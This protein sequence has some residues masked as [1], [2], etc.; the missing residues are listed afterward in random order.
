MSASAVT[1]W[2]TD[3]PSI[4]FSVPRCDRRDPFDTELCVD[5][6]VSLRVHSVLNTNTYYISSLF[7][8]R[9]SSLYP[10]TYEG[11]SWLI[12]VGSWLDLLPPSLQLQSITTAH[13]QW[14]SKTRSVPYW[15]TSV[16]ASTVN[17]LVPIYE[18]VTSSASVASWLTLH[19]WTL[20]SLTNEWRN[21]WL[22]FLLRLPWTTTVLQCLR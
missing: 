12:I 18:S 20:N 10:A 2:R 6:S 5:V 11:F 8:A 22:S 14:L 3:V 17:E 16:F 15:T 4:I 13:N 1:F 19:R 21:S 9:D 7:E